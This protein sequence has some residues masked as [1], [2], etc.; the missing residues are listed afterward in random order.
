MI[1]VGIEIGRAYGLILIPLILTFMYLILKKLKRIVRKDKLVLVS[2]IILLILIVIG[3]SDITINLKGENISTVFLL[4]VSDSMSEF[5][6]EGVKFIDNA[7]KEMPKNNKAGVVVFG[8]NTSVDKFMDDNKEY[9]Q[10]KSAPIVNS[11]NIE[12]AVN[13][14]LSLFDKGAAKRI[15]LITDGE[16]NQGDL[17]KNIPIIKK[18][19][20]DFKVYKVENAKADEVYVEDVKVPDNISIGE[21]FSV[22]TKIQSNVQTKAKLTLFS[23]RDKKGEQEVELQKGTNT[24]VF[25]DVQN[26]GGFK[27]YRVLIEP[28]K[29][30]NKTNNE[31]SCFTNVISKPNILIIEGKAGSGTGVIETLKAV[32]SEYNV[33]LPTGA[34][35]TLNQM[36]EYKTIVLADVHADDLNKGFMENVEAYVK[37]Y[38][39]GIVTFGGENSYA[40]GGY[41]DTALEK[42][43]PVNMD[44]KGKNEVPQI[45]ISLVID[46]SGSM[47]GGDG[48]VS[49]L[50]LAKEAA[51]KSLDNLRPTDEINVIAFDDSYQKVVER[52]PVKDKEAIKGMIAG[53]GNGGGTSIYPALEEAY[54]AQSESSAKIK[55]VILLTDGQD[56]FGIDNY[57]DLIGDINNGGITLSTVSVG[58][59][60]D[61]SL[62]GK[63]AEMGKGRAYHTDKYT[64]IPRIFAKEV[65][66]SAGTYIINEEF[67]PKVVSNHEILR[68]VLTD[69]SIPALKGYVGTS[70]K[71]KAIE[72]LSSNHDEPI[73]S[74]N[75]YGLGKTVSWT[76]DINGQ[77]SGDFLTWNK[78]AQLIR[79]AIYWTIPDLSEEGKVSITQKGNEAVVEFYS[80]TVKE[81]SK[82]KGVYNSEKGEKGEL[83]LTQ[84][85]PGKF[86]GRVKLNELGFYTF[87]IREENNGEV[88]NNYNGAFSLQYS[89]E[90]KFNKNKNKIDTVVNEVKGTFINKPKDVFKGELKSNYKPINLTIPALITAILLFFLDIAY[91]RLNLDI[92]KYFNK[93]KEKSGIGNVKFNLIFKR[94]K[95]ESSINSSNSNRDSV[96]QENKEELNLVKASENKGKEEAVTKEHIAKRKDEVK[97]NKEKTKKQAERLDTSSLLKNKRKREE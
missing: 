10:I 85:E 22:I 94:K 40:L 1:I 65:L 35:T 89:E 60:A 95:R 97:V 6:G 77:W 76:S 48:N 46:K 59:D 62:L 33:T 52:Q 41:K 43:L 93:F 75:Q 14:S 27:S 32:N 58:E 3:I 84:E 29:D 80:D 63:L 25:K 37:D 30:S 13:S 4:D 38:G 50:T 12:E 15:V 17:L 67:Q 78:G 8:D 36:L 16:E 45:S 5:K 91:R 83:E 21:E 42:V 87:N 44:K 49:K 64:D 66:L 69:N 73:L 24:F 28:E 2:R 86:V 20:I 47:S 51:M 23:G 53:I 70:I 56:D 26:T 68:G 34:P 81:G 96:N 61:T 11:T 54:N 82:I 39:G 79:N 57:K 74:A 9:K 90:Y 88:S 19:N 31:Y 71:D 18:E 55:H 92:K 7:L 72:I